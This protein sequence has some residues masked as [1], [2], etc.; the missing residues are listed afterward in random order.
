M[1]DE[2]VDRLGDGFA[3]GESLEVAG[4]EVVVEGVRMVPVESPA[5]VE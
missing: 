2:V 1:A 5:L 3:A 4:E